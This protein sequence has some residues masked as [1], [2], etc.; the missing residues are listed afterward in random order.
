VLKINPILEEFEIK[1][2]IN[3]ILQLE[4]VPYV[5]QDKKLKEIKLQQI[6]ETESSV[7]SSHVCYQTK[8]EMRRKLYASKFVLQLKENNT[9]LE[10][11]VSGAI[12]F[13]LGIVADEGFR[14][15]LH[16]VAGEV[17]TE[18]HSYSKS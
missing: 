12:G 6:S 8:S 14:I 11:L 7:D 17:A 9:Y 13:L 10:N 4:D 2:K 18:L 3:S 16:K 15:Y 1:E 5:F